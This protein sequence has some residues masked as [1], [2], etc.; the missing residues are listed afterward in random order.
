MRSDPCSPSSPAVSSRF[1]RN[2]RKKEGTKDRKKETKDTS[3]GRR[4]DARKRVSKDAINNG[5]KLI[6]EGRN[7]RSYEGMNER[8]EEEYQARKQGQRKEAR[9]QERKGRKEG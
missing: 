4:Y 1:P 8:R 2:L 5:R 9:K 6:E 3:Q 7:K